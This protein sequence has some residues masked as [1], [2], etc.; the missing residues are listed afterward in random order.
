MKFQK[1]ENEEF[2]RPRANPDANE[3]KMAL[4]HVPNVQ[5]SPPKLSGYWQWISA[6]LPS[7][8]IEFKCFRLAAAGFRV[9]DD[10]ILARSGLEAALYL[11]FLRAILWLLLVVTLVCTGEQACCFTPL[12]RAIAVQS[13]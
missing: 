4:P 3:S 1:P 11:Q 9:T 13:C 7:A 10:E 8:A 12:K 6:L 2:I 5:K